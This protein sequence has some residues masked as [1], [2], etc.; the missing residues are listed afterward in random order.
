MT[1]NTLNISGIGIACISISLAIAVYMFLRADLPVLLEPFQPSHKSSLANAALFGSAPSLLYTLSIGVLLGTIAPN[2]AAARFH[3]LG[4]TA[5]ALL[6]E[7]TQHAV[8]ARPVIGVLTN[9]F[10]DPIIRIVGPYWSRGVFDPLDLLATL[11][12]GILALVIVSRLA[13]GG[14][15]V[16]KR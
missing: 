4:W 13:S 5:I 9:Y 15:H 1:R 8:F 2:P 11:I 16:D 3:C 6:L 10:P 12:G 14:N 7:V